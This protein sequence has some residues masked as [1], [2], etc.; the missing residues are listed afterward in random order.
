MFVTRF[1]GAQNRNNINKAL[2]RIV[3]DYNESVLGAL[4]DGTIEE[5]EMVLLP[6]ISCHDLRH[7]CATRLCEASGNL[8][9]IQDMLGHADIATTMNIYAEAKEDLK[10]KELM[11]YDSYLTRQNQNFTNDEEK[12]ICHE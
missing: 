1:G 7:T 9:F 11:A 6:K 8:K 5:S 10:R 2:R 4:E 12:E 3:R